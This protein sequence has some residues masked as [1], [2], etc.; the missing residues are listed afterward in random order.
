M[1]EKCSFVGSFDY[2]SVNDKSGN[3]K[4]KGIETLR[5]KFI[6]VPNREITKR[7]FKGQ[8]Q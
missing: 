8:K 1:K 2:E 7:H 3:G 5:T 6:N 4:V